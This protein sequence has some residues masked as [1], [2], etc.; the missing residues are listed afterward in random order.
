MPVVEW[1]DGVD[2]VIG[3]DLTAAAAYLTPAGGVVVTGVAPC[4][5]RDRDRGV[6]SFTTSLGFAKKL[7]RIIADP[8]VAM[9]YHAREHGFSASPRFVVAQGLA[10]VDLVPSAQRLEALA[11][12]AERYLGEIKRGPVWD[13]VLREYYSE[14][15][16]V[17]ITVQRVIAWPDPAAAGTPEVFG[18]RLAEPPHFQPAPKNG[19]SPRVGMEKVVQQIAVL[20]HR[21][22]AYRGAD[23]LPVVVPVDIAGHGSTGLQLVTSQGLLPPGARR[24]GLLAHSYR[25]HL[26]GLSTRTFTGWLDVSKDGSAVYAPHTSKGFRAPPLKELLLI[27]NGLLAKYGMWHAR[28]AGVL[29]KLQ[30]LSRAAPTVKP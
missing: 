20:P 27:S 14:R 2:E 30:Q 6:I 13:R 29:E 12:R 22:L 28:R 10:S 7:E 17:D 4:G 24:A 9:A 18:G 5:M 15:V 1:S 23:G 25:P 3:G 16:F 19:T 21:V 11:P 26:V 8:R